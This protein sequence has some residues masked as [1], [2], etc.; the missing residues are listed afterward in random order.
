M[1]LVSTNRIYKKNTLYLATIVISKDLMLGLMKIMMVNG[2]VATL[3]LKWIIVKWAN[4]RLKDI[5]F[6]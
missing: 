1:W 6:Y 4:I 5:A 3:I 2:C